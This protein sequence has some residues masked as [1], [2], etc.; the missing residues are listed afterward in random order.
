DHPRVRRGGRGRRRRRGHRA[1]RHLRR[2][3]GRGRRRGRDR[4]RG[5]L[6]PP[7]ADRGPPQG[8]HRPRPAHAGQ[9]QLHAQRQDARDVLPEQA[10][11][12]AH[13]GAARARGEDRALRH[14]RQPARR[15]H[16]GPG[17]RAAPGHRPR[18]DRGRRGGP[19]A[20]QARRLPHSRPAGHRAQEV[21]P[22]EGPQGPA[23]QQAL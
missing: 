11:P 8:G 15:G 17:R 9:R 16:L 3:R 10:A 12:A 13:P 1:G 4:A 23:V 21:R 7:G 2:V 14:L 18:A 19:P 20:A 22:Q 5:L 6:R